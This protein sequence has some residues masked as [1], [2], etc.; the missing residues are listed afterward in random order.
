MNI[1]III[2]EFQFSSDVGTTINTYHRMA[3]T[4]ASMPIMADADVDAADAGADELAES[5]IATLPNCPEIGRHA[6]ILTMP[7]ELLARRVNGESQSSIISPFSLQ[8]GCSASS[9]TCG[10]GNND[11]SRTRRDS[12]RI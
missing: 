7:L 3:S 10:R 5:L 12:M 9:W 11:D 6:A 4:S 1:I 2:I 8:D